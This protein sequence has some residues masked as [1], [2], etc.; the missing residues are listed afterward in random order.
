MSYLELEADVMVSD[1]E[2]SDEECVFSVAQ[3]RGHLTL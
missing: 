2:E 1:E 3:V